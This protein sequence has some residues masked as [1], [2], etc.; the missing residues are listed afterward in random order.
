MTAE[1]GSIVLRPVETDPL[2]RV[3]EKLSEL[4]VGE[5]GVQAA[6]EGARTGE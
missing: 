2:G 5:E 1:G 4:G 6:V 3:R